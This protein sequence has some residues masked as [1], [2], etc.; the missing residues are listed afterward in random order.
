MS[1][2]FATPWTVARQGSIHGILQVRLLEGVAIPFSQGLPDPGIKSGSPALQA[3]SLRLSEPPGKPV[4]RTY[5]RLS[6]FIHFPSQ[7]HLSPHVT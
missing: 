1:L 2:S 5:L 4:F 6:Q 7:N 3:D